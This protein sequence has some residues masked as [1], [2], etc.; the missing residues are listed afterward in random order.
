[1]PA[2]NFYLSPADGWTQIA[3]SPKFVRVSGYPHTHPYYVYAG[4]SA[5]SL[6]PT[7]ATGTLT[8]AVGVPIADE[9]VTIGAE[10]YTFKAARAN[11]FEVTIG[12]DNAT[13]AANF[14]TAVNTDST[15]VSAT[16][17]T[18]VVTLHAYVAGTAGNAITTTEAATNVSFGGATLSGGAAIVEGILVCHHPFKVNVTMAEKLWARVPT[19]VPNANKNDGKIRLDVFTIT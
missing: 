1:M 12:A 8:F 19:P 9:T 14:V 4:A 2:A 17:V 18:N 3:D 10:V 13:T 16:R 11:P 7:A 5:P 6:V 15:L